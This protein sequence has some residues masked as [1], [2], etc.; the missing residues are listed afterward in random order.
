[1]NDTYI[2]SAVRTPIGKGREGGALADV[3]PD[4]LAA[5]TLVEVVKRAGLVPKDVEDI[6]MGCVTQVGEQGINVGRV[7]PLLAGFPVEV[8]A[9][10]VNRM[11]GS[12]QQ[13][14]HFVSQAIAAGDIDIGI[15]AGV[16]SMSRVPIGSDWTA[17]LHPEFPYDLVPQGISA[18]M[19]AEKWEL[20]RDEL[21]DYSY[22]SHARAAE[23]TNECYFSRE[24]MPIEVEKDGDKVTVTVD[25]G[26]RFNPDREKMAQLDPVFKLGG[27]VTAGNSS[28]ISDGAA[29][30]LVASEKAL[31]EYDLTPR[32]RIVARVVVGVD[33]VLML[34]GP[35]PAT[36]KVLEKAG[37]TLDDIDL[38]E[39]NEAFASVVLAWAKELQPDMDK[40]NVNGGAIAL[41]HPL[42]ASGAR[43]MVTLLHELERHGGRYGL[44]TMCI[45]HGM[46]TAT[47]IERVEN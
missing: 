8:P 14:I 1:M 5:Q 15:G 18:E 11:C 47:I 26:I 29:A 27:V 25:E 44:Q 6:V 9:V 39:V 37:M 2:V 23:A 13:A 16:E 10:S 3:R 45:G 24:I 34:S 43:L 17:P 12:S 40:V 41:G 20:T 21:D 35:I 36:H 46:A 38:F 42:G 4:E 30:V 31:K 28:Q 32:A 33:P 7:A 19:M 22:R